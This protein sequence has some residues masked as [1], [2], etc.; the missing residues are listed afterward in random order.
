M[1]RIWWVAFTLPAVAAAQDIPLNLFSSLAAKGAEVVEVN[2]DLGMLQMAARFLSGKDPDEAKVKDLI[3]GLKGIYVRNFTFK[4]PGQYSPSDLDQVRA[5]LKGWNQVVNVR[6]AEESTGVY[7]KSDGQKIQGLV[8]VA[9]EPQALTFI[10]I[11]GSIRPDQLKELSGKFGIPD[12][13]DLGSKKGETKK[14][15]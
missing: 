14:E 2:L 1:N 6:T 3:A 12:L 5:Q 7:L 13:G 8:V 15:E 10:D 4:Q 9:A 11:V